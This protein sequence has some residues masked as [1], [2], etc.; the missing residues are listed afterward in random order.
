MMHGVILPKLIA[1]E[2]TMRPIKDEVFADQKDDHLGDQRQRGDGAVTVLIERDQPVG[3]GDAEQDG[4][5]GD[6]HADAQE[7]RDHRDEQPIADVGDKIGLAPP[8]TARIARPEPG[9]D[10]EDESQR[11]R[12]RHASHEGLTDIDDEAEQLLTHV[13]I[14]SRF[15]LVFLSRPA[16]VV[17]ARTQSQISRMRINTR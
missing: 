14:A 16:S 5:A 7:P 9:Q 15:W 8:R 12:N 13:M 4:G 10:R 11:Q 17:R 2:E 3:G 1:V 6:Q